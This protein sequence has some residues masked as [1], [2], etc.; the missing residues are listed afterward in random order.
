MQGWE[1][2][3][4]A[5]RR[6]L[7]FADFDGSLAFANRVAQ[8][9]DEADHHPDLCVSWDTVTLRWVSH[10]AGGITERDVAMAA[11]QRQPRLS[12][13][14]GSSAGCA[15]EAG[16]PG[17]GRERH[18]DLGM[19]GPSIALTSNRAPSNATVSPTCGARPSSP[20]TNPPT[21]W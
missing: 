12:T 21:V 2:R 8:A 14:V 7:Q 10:S 4:G 16:C 6:R 15:G 11:K 18:V 5:L 20:K 17:G 3:D 1:V 9:A 13:S 19:R